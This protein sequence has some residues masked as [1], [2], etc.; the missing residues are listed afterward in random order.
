MTISMAPWRQFVLFLLV[1]IGSLE[2][3]ADDLVIPGS[4]NPEYILG[5]LASAFNQRQAQHRVI[6]PPSTGTAGALRDVGEG[7]SPLGRV[8]RLLKDEESRQGFIF[9]P[10]GR[11]PVAVVGG[12]GV[13]VR[14]LSATQLLDVYSGRITNW[15]EL[16][17]KPAPIR[18]VGRENSDASRQALTKVIK[19]FRD[20][21][22]GPEV[23]IVHLDPR[24]IELLDRYPSSLG[25]LN[26]SALA[27][28][29]SRI[30]LLA[31][32]GVEPTPENVEKGHYQAWVEL[33]LI[34]KS[35][36]LPPAARAFLDFVR[37]A[38]GQGILRRHGILPPAT[39]R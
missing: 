23:K 37:A 35:G 29:S 16:G 24:L 8:G 26:R 22:F 18:A 17:G 6:I 36:G 28:C 30:V 11:D 39:G 31:L 1:L 27:A 21:V 33:G 12:A 14:T 9:V 25:F 38:E 3:L 2:V 4:G 13:T 20:V 7:T 5:Q 15:R 19:P 10:L 34:H 32:D